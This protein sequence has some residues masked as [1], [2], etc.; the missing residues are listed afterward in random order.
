MSKLYE[1]SAR[2]TSAASPESVWR[3]LADVETWSDWA[4]F[5]SSEL[6]RPAD[7]GGQGAGAIRR[8]KRRGVTTRER[9]IA[10]EEPSRLTYELLS[11]LPIS[12]YNADVTLIPTAGGGTEIRWD[13]RFRGRFPVPGGL[14]RRGLARFVQATADNLAR[15]AEREPAGDA[16]AR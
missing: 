5:D 9:V 15:A 10:A 14:M 12:D 8:F 2:A 13:S 3:L 11:G 7:D 16:G 1:I 6:E 4:D